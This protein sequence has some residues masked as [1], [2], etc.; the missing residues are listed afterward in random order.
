[1]LQFKPGADVSMLNAIMH[2]IVDE[3]LYD[4][5]Y[6]A[7]FTENWPAMKEHLKGFPPENMAAI[8]GIDAETLRDVA[9]TFANA[10]A[11]MIFWGMERF[12]DRAGRSRRMTKPA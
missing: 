4:E 10:R 11:A 5:Q 3:G 9:R 1:M 12:I 8:C 6:I 7:A 2:T